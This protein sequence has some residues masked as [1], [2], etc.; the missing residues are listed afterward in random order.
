[1][2]KHCLM[3]SAPTDLGRMRDGVAIPFGQKLSTIRGIADYVHHPG[4]APEPAVPGWGGFS[5]PPLIAL[6]I[7]LFAMSGVALFS[8]RNLS[9]ASVRIALTAGRWRSKGTLLQQQRDLERR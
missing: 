4:G 5:H 3:T 6:T 8:R 7:A 9:P 1:M 2:R